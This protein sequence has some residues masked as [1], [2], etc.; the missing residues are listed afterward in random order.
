M[1]TYQYV[2]TECQT[3]HEAVQ[4]FT[5]SALTDCPSCSGRLRKVFS[6]VGITFKGSGFYRT[7]SRKDSASPAQATTSGTTP[8]P[9]AA[10]ATATSAT[11]TAPA[12]SSTPKTD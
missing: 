6:S 7:D 3:P 10:A 11:P 1:P 5:D 8:A 2:C 4:S 9:A 12:T